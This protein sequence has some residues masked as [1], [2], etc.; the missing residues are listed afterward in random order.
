MPNSI[1]APCKVCGASAEEYGEQELGFFLTGIRCGYDGCNSKP[2]ALYATV[3]EAVQAWN[4]ANAT[5]EWSA[6]NS[7]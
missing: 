6:E 4:D 5:P 2:T 7:E 1:L 3:A